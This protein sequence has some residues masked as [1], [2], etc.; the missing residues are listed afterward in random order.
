MHGHMGT[1]EA[2]VVVQL[3]G[4][5]ITMS[6]LVNMNIG[7]VIPLNRDSDGELDVLVEGVSKFKCYFG[8]S[9]GNRAVQIT[10]P[11]KKD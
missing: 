11:I 8:T 2:D 10:R 7:D 9:R 4:A 1:V 5:N 3:G 6:D